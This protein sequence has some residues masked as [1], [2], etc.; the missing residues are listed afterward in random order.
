[1]NENLDPRKLNLIKI[2]V[3]EIERRNIIKKESKEAMVEE[4]RKY[5]EKVVDGKC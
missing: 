1:M 4:I 2:K 5:I 3:I